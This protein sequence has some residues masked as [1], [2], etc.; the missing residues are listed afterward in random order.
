MRHRRGG[1]ALGTHSNSSGLLLGHRPH[2]LAGHVP[3]LEHV[4]DFLHVF[5][6]SHQE[7]PLLGFGKHHL[8]TGHARLPTVHLV[9]IQHKAA[10]APGY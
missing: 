3:L 1:E 4:A 9:D 7:H 8:I 2:R 6:G 5:F 10:P